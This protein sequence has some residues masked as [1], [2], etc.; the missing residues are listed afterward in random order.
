MKPIIFFTRLLFVLLFGYALS[1]LLTDSFLFSLPLIV[2]LITTLTGEWDENT[3]IHLPPLLY[4]QSLAPGS[5]WSAKALKGRK[6]GKGIYQRRLKRFVTVNNA[7]AM[8]S[9]RLSRK[10]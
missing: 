6:A 2:I 3:S 5:L 8:Q 4:A 7:P 10:K 9:L 1:L